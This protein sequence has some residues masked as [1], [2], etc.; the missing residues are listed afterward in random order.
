[1]SISLSDAARALGIEVSALRRWIRRAGIELVRDPADTR[2]RLLQTEDFERLRRE[3]GTLALV[4]EEAEGEEHQRSADVRDELEQLRDSVRKQY[5]VL[6]EQMAV[7]FLQF[8]ELA[9]RVTQL[10]EDLRRAGAI[11]PEDPMRPRTG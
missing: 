3:R 1:M 5:S 8:S 4:T 9:K 2:R 6:N 7:L 11:Q 10:E